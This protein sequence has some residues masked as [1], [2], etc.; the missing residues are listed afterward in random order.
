MRDGNVTPQSPVRDL[1]SKPVAM[2]GLGDSL[3]HVA[4]ELAANAIG[5]VLVTTDT[6]CVGIIT[7]RDLVE[8]I[9]NGAN[10]Q[11]LTAEEVL[12]SELVTAEP[13]ES[14][15]RAAR[16]M[17]EAGIRHLP[18]CEDGDVIGLVSVRDVLGVLVAAQDD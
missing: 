9:A 5:A 15:A 6:N 10:L 11:N 4:E 7:E 16:L 18:V 14:V 3:A 8:H 12:S 17:V 2:V 1:M 13:A